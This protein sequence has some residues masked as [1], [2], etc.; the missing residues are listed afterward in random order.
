MSSNLRRQDPQSIAPGAVTTP[1]TSA[2]ATHVARTALRRLYLARFAFAVAWAGLLAT[3]ASSLGAFAAVLLVTYPAFDVAAAIIDGRASARAGAWPAALSL[4]I[5]ISTVAA[6]GLAVAGAA[7]IPT[8]LRVWGAWAVA[9]GI[10]QLVVGRARRH[11][12]GQWPM[13]LSGGISAVAGSSFVLSASDAVSM[14]M[15]AGYAVLGGV[16]FLASAVRLGRSSRA[17]APSSQEC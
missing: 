10:V 3:T 7:D 9:S 16:F 1:P 8:V 11:L 13:M 2:A 12:G 4:N 5:A 6:V 14:S 15:V 17:T